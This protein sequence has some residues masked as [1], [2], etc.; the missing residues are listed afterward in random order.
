M[1]LT[2]RQKA[3]MLLMSLD[4]STATELI[5]GLGADTVQAIAVE[6][7]YLDASGLRNSRQSEEVARQFCESLDSRPAFHLKNFL[8]HALTNTVGQ[9]QAE[10]IQRQLQTLVYQRDPFLPIRT[11]PAAAISKALEGEHPQV[12]AVVLSELDPKVSSQV[13]GTL[14]EGVRLSVIARMTRTEQMTPEARG[15]IAETV[16]N[17]LK[18]L[19][20]GSNGD[21]DQRDAALRRVAVILRNLGKDLRDGL[22]EAIGEKDAQTRRSVSQL[23]VVWEDIP[24]ITDRSLQEALRGIDSQKLALALHKAEE[25]IARKIRVNISER[26]AQMLDEEAS[27]MSS[28]TR[29]DVGQ[30][31][32]HVVQTLR[33]ANEK[34]ALAFMED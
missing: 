33:D 6:M 24:T 2:G 13:L 11:A 26:A 18:S 15:R 17:R 22:L 31:R 34:G 30:A 5:K 32:E 23:M 10:H 3:A 9:E 29:E 12:A 14:G 20:G 1:A 28:P 27:L 25:P 16:C 21:V 19:G 8:R 7:A 4:M